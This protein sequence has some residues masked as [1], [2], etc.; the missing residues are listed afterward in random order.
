MRRILTLLLLAAAPVMSAQRRRAITPPS[1]PPCSIVEGTPGVTFTRDEGNSLSPVAQRLEGVAYTYGLAALD[2]PDTLLSWHGST[3]SISSDAGCHWRSLGDYPYDFP[4]SITAAPGGRAYI[5]SDNR[6]FL[7]RYDERGVVTL[8]A[9]GAFIGLA[10]NANDGAHVRAA[11]GTGILWES[12]DAGV[13]WDFAGGLGMQP[14]LYRFAFDPADLDHVIAGTV[15]NGAWVSRDG[16]R[17]W[18]RATGFVS[19]RV[20]A[21]NI[22]ISPVDGNTV[23][24]MAL[25]MGDNDSR[26]IYLSRDGGASYTT[27]VD[28]GPDVTLVNGPIMAAHPTNG[29]VL[30]FIFGTFFQGYGTDL[31][32]YDAAARE[33]TKTHNQY[34]D[35][36]AIAFARGHANVM[37]LGL[38]VEQIR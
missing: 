7:M 14:G 15:V 25:D 18:T 20:N 28:A 26:H 21:F 8:K 5:W 1:Y 2:I 22:A 17:H 29:D 10:V 35:V 16:G 36:N 37:Y 33:L 9:P 6:L 23:W 34:S 24:L 13:T 27:V 30:Y 38:E 32:R 12:R 11:D 4:P 19:E 31:F 3:L